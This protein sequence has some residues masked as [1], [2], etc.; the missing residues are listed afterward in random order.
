MSDHDGQIILS[1]SEHNVGFYLPPGARQNGR[2]ALP[3][4]ALICGTFVGD[5]LCHSGSVIIA[6]G[7]KFRGSIE[8]N[9]IYVVGHISSS[10]S[11]RS[12]IVARELLAAASSAQ[13]NA[14]LF[15]PSWAL[16]KPKIWGLMESLDD[17]AVA[18]LKQSAAERASRAA[19][20][21]G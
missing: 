1:L 5:M 8:A 18:K 21:R 4:G 9:R 14:D 12:R 20:A 15:A 13:I 3:Y 2:L 11:T 16:H 19:P 10:E 7:A 6:E 17:E